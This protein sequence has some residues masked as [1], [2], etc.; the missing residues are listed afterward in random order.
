M[1]FFAADLFLLGP[2]ALPHQLQQQENS[3]QGQ[4]D[5]YDASCLKE[6]GLVPGF[7]TKG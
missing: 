2:A 7:I 4:E 6:K 1:E 5:R 3:S